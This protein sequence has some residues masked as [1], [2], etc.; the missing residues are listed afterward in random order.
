MP[1]QNIFKNQSKAARQASAYCALC[2][3]G[4]H[5]TQC[6][7]IPFF[8]ELLLVAVNILGLLVSDTS[9]KEIKLAGEILQKDDIAVS[10]LNLI[11]LEQ[12][13]KNIKFTRCFEPIKSHN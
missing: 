1:L 5:F 13:L 2:Q 8:Q 4:A 12:K 7:N 6:P 10:T 9:D 3:S 11:A